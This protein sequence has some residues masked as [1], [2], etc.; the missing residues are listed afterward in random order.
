MHVDALYDFIILCFRQ[1]FLHFLKK[2]MPVLH[3]L[4]ISW[5][6]RDTKPLFHLDLCLVRIAA[7]MHLE[8]IFEI[9]V[10]INSAQGKHPAKS[11]SCTMTHASSVP[12]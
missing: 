2:E 6:F 10:L 9:T 1:S 11:R 3:E 8:K 5:E 4:L 7:L 12:A